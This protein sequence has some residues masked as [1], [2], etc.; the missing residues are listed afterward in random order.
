[1][2]KGLPELG[3][4]LQVE[5][6][7]PEPIRQVYV[8]KGTDLFAKQEQEGWQRAEHRL[9]EALSEFAQAARSTYQGRLFAQDALQRLRLI[10]LCREVFDVVVMNPPFGAAS[11]RDQEPTGEG[12]S[13]QQ[14][15]P[16]GHLRRTRVGAI[17]SEW[18]HRRDHLAYLLFPFQLSE[19]AGAGGARR[20][21]PRS[22]GGSGPWR[23]GRCDGGSRGLCAGKAMN[24][25][26]E[27]Q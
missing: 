7:L 12:L 22:H 9:R 5:H 24:W 18:P 25:I 10:D 4:L 1:M 19:M 13:T 21:P 23:D 27:Q 16:A 11:Q 15:R 2:L 14:E 20:C 3:M 17:A 8:G 26:G 6:E